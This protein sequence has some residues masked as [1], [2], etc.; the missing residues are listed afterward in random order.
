MIDYKVA[1][2][3]KLVELFCAGQN[4][5]F[6]ELLL[7]Y[8]D[9]LYSYITYI[10]KNSDMADDL[11]QETFVKAIVTLR[12]GRYQAN[13]RFYAWLTRIAHNLL[14]DQF[15]TERSVSFVYEEEAE[16][17]TNA[18]YD[19]VIQNRECEISNEQVLKDVRRLI[20]HLPEAQRE[21]V[22]MRYYQNMSFKEISDLKGVS[23]NTA[24]GRMHYAIINMRK[25]A[26]ENHISLSLG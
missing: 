15:R 17:N 23:I 4:E 1:T 11:F 19:I 14:M 21:I 18:L 6:D 26:A 9:R 3:D 13:G 20:D 5:A 10:V 25:M 12:Q 8:K 16:G 22:M 2:D 24:L 7:R